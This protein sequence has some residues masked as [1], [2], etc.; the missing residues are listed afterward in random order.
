MCLLL[1][2]PGSG[3]TSLLKA[4]AGKYHA[5]KELEARTPPSCSCRTRR[6]PRH[7]RVLSPGTPNEAGPVAAGQG[8]DHLQRARFQVRGR[9]ALA[10]AGL[11][12]GQGAVH[13]T[14]AAAVSLC[15]CARPAMSTSTTCTWPSSP[16]GAP[17][18]PGIPCLRLCCLCGRE[19]S[20]A[21]QGQARGRAADR[22][23]LC[24]QGDPGLCQALQ[25][26]GRSRQ[27]APRSRMQLHGIWAV[28]GT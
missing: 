26:R 2:P 9:P 3:K 4:L 21:S 27:C 8:P 24:A 19:P 18:V 17:L 12:R 14:L 1:G 10:C 20:C 13:L 15:P 16:S 7:P 22:G 11:T 5:T 23:A 25:R 6:R 28:P